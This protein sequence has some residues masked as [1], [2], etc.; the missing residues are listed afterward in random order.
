MQNRSFYSRSLRPSPRQR[1]CHNLN[2]SHNVFYHSTPHITQCRTQK[3]TKIQENCTL[4]FQQQLSDKFQKLSTSFPYLLQDSYKSP[5]IIDLAIIEIL[6][7]SLYQLSNLKPNCYISKTTKHITFKVLQVYQSI[8][9][10]LVLSFQN[11]F[12]SCC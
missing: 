7:I 5:S 4:I 11:L 2:Q 10:K 1:I 12:L 9:K 8:Y 3:H 6:S